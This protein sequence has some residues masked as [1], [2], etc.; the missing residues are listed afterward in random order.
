MR[1][2]ALLASAVL[3]GLPAVASAA[4]DLTIPSPTKSPVLTWTAGDGAGPYSVFRDAGSCSGMPAT[5]LSGATGL[6]VL[7]INDDSPVPADG[8]YC[9]GVDDDVATNPGTQTVLVDNT[10]PSLSATLPTTATFVGGNVNVPF[11]ASDSGSGLDQVLLQTSPTG[12]NT[13]TTVDSSNSSSGTLTWNTSSDGAFEVRVVAVDNLTNARV[14]TSVPTITVDNTDPS[15]TPTY[16]SAGAWLRST[17]GVAYTADD[18]TGSGVASVKLQYS[19]DGGSSWN[20]SVTSASPLVWNTASV[21]DGDYKLRIVVTDGVSNVF[22]ATASATVHV[23]N[24]APG[25]A[26][27][28]G[29]PQNNATLG[30]GMITVPYSGATDAGGVASVAF[31]A[32]IVGQTAWV[33][34]ATKSSAPFTSVQW[35]PQAA[36]DCTC[37]FRLVV[38]DLAGNTSV[39]SSRTNVKLDNFAPVAP[40]NFRLDRTITNGPPILT[41]AASPSGDVVGYRLLRDGVDLQ[42]GGGLIAGLTYTDSGLPRDG[43]ADGAHGYVIYANDGGNDSSPPVVANFFLD[44]VAPDAPTVPTAKRR[45]STKLV[46]LT[47]TGSVDNVG[48]SV[49]SGVAR[50]VVR[51]A[52]SPAVPTS[53]TSGSLACDVAASLESCVD[54]TAPEG[55]TYRYGVFA[56]DAG[57]NGSLAALPGAVTIPDLTA[58]GVPSAF[59]VKAKGAVIAITWGLPTAADL[60]R[61]VIV[62]N[63]SRAPRNLTDGKAIYSGKAK[64]F[65]LRQKAG[66]TAWYRAFAVD[67]AGNFSATAGVRIRLPIFKLFP[68]NGSELRGT[69]R[70]TWKKPKKATYFNVQVYL[71]S[72]RVTQTWP[73]NASFKIP[74]SKLQKGKTYTWYVWPG[75]GAKS[76]GRYGT[77]IGKSTFTWMG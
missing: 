73:K 68:E 56:V 49:M 37:N 17:I 12:T 23:D 42:G 67:K 38:T 19:D 35:T 10:A 57:G 7:T 64:S 45:G 8:T 32:Q 74:R 60:N 36:D 2:V 70:L 13:Y 4:I 18:G 29:T 44:T 55:A 20:N 69:V 66:T 21:S 15:G 48:N 54:T 65:S 46:D 63:A 50:Y 41:W 40:S 24:T 39:S 27:F 76:A 51:R 71:G 30:A 11:S 59:R 33:T 16:P 28:T 6:A 43:T 14:S 31:Q 72:K 3:F 1:R 26:S 53:I 5:P 58:P 25:T 9:Y 62:R 77:M 61:V 52:V 22:N 47:W 75:V 34:K